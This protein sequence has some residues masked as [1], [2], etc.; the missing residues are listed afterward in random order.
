MKTTID[1][2]DP[3]LEQARRVA[4]RRGT[5]LKALVEQG[6]KAVLTE[7]RSPRAFALRDASFRG[8]GLQPGVSGWSW[9]NLRDSAYEGRGG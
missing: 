8:K 6:L 9:E 3:L 4:G 7:E 1:I 5:T 2:A